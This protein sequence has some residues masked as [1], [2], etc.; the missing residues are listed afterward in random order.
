MLVYTGDT[1]VE[2]NPQSGEFG[3]EEVNPIGWM[4]LEDLQQ[5]KNIRPGLQYILKAAVDGNWIAKLTEQW[6]LHQNGKGKQIRPVL[7]LSV[8]ENNRA[9]RTDIGEY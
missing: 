5:N 1:N 6:Q 2:F 8:A 7:T 3:I 4:K 9:T